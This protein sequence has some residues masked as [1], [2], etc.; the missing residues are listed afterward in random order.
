MARYSAT[1]RNKIFNQHEAIR[2][3]EDTFSFKSD[4]NGLQDTSL[5]QWFI[6]FSQ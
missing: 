3:T 1:L 2:L 4:R 5:C 6:T